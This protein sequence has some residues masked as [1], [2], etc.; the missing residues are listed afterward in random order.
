MKEDAN[1]YC[2]VTLISAISKILEKVTV[3]QLICFFNKPNVLNKYQFGFWKNKFT[4]DAI[5]TIIKNIIENLNNKIKCNCVL[6]DLPKH[7]IALNITFLWINC[8]NMEF[9]VYHIS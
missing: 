7:L 3:H 5:T 4:K 6:L 2:P 9:I 8:T 1:N